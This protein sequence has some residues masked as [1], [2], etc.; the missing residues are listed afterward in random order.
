MDDSQARSLGQALAILLRSNVLK[1][2]EEL[3]GML[4]RFLVESP[5]PFAH[6]GAKV[7]AQYSDAESDRLLR[8]ALTKI[9]LE[10]PIRFEAALQGVLDNGC[11]PKSSVSEI[12]R[13]VTSA[14]VRYRVSD[15]ERATRI[16]NL[17]RDLK[18]QAR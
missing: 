3:R 14:Y 17:L 5:G 7:L 15:P 18:L 6:L 16:V 11:V 13:V 10:L 9:P 4:H 12:E 2:S 8:D 1:K